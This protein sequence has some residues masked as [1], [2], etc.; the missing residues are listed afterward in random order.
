M[1]LLGFTTE[2]KNK[3]DQLNFPEGGQKHKKKIP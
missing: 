3:I 2:I 1:S